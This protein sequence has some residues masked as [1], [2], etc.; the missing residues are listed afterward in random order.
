MRRYREMK[1]KEVNST[2]EIP[3]MIHILIDA[4]I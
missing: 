3:P 1:E 4:K 2:S